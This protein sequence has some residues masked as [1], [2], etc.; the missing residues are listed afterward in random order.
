TRRRA[1][2]GA[3]GLSFSAGLREGVVREGVVMTRLLP[4]QQALAES[5]FH[6]EAMC[7][8]PAALPFLRGRLRSPFLAGKP[9]PED[10]TQRMPVR[11]PD[12]PNR[13]PGRSP[14]A[15]VRI[16]RSPL[17][18]HTSVGDDIKP[19]HLAIVID[20]VGKAGPQVDRPAVVP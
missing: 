9:V 14:A 20:G 19:G 11:S 1:A 6:P 17:G 15:R 12:A 8:E 3:T 10:L 16:T 5:A 13:S 2:A 4:L 18:M 7:P